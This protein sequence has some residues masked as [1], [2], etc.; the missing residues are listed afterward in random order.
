M[1]TKLTNTSHLNI[2]EEDW[3]PAEDK[4][5][6]ERATVEGMMT[7]SPFINVFPVKKRRKISNQYTD[8][9]KNDNTVISVNIFS[10]LLH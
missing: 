4:G 10:I 9:I 5:S 2:S 3:L 1:I 6:V 7:V 8:H